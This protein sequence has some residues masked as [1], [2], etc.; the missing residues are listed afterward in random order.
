[1]IHNAIDKL[2]SMGA[3]SE[4]LA[5]LVDSL[6]YDDIHVAKLDPHRQ[7]RQGIPEVVFAQ[8]KEI[9]D[10]V[11]IVNSLLPKTGHVLI[12][13]AEHA[14]Y[15]SL[16]H[17]IPA[18][19][20]RYNKRGRTIVV[21]DSLEQKDLIGHVLVLSAGTS[22]IGV[23][24]EAA[25]TVAYLGSRVQRLYDVGVAGL[26]R[27]MDHLDLIRQARVLIVVA[28]ME[29]ALPSVVGGLTTKPIIATPTSV[30]YGAS[31]NGITAL[32]AMLNSC[33][34]GI[35]VMNIDNGFGAG[36]LA[37]KINALVELEKN[38]LR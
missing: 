4:D 20:I 29:G 24:E 3:G 9:E 36:C 7:A 26:H 17:N 34:P 31:L 10:I 25:E 11:Q 19:Q 15:E 18:S 5:G 32:F 16:L 8:G 37:H 28:G 2:K 13:R 35:A 6:T 12:T 38:Q 14:V 23:A 1:L 27:L 21:T 22:D 33:V 30:G